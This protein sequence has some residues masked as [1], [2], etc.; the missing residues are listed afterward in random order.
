MIEFLRDFQNMSMY[1]AYNT[2]VDAIIY[3]NEK[4]IQTLIKEFGAENVK[5]RMQE[6]PRE[7][8]EPLDFVARLIHALKTGKPQSVPLMSYEVD[9]WFNSRFEHGVERIGGQV[10][11]IANLLANL[12]FKKV[13][14]YSPLL[15]K[16]QAEMFVRRDNLLYPVVENGKLI[17]KKP[18]EAYKE[19]DPVK[20]NRIF[21]FRAGMRFNLGNEV[22][23]VPY[24]GRFI[25]ACRSEEFARVETSSNFKPYLPEI[26]EMVDGAILSGYQGIRNHYTD[27]KNANYYLRKAKEDI[28]LLKKKKDVKIHVEFASI[29]DRDLRKKVIFNIFPLADSVGMDEA[30]IAHILSVLGYRDLSDRIFTYNRIEDTILGAK[31]L[32]DELNLEVLQIHTI[33]YLMYITHRDNPL[34]EGDLLK[35]LEVGTTLA[36]TRAL[37]GDIKRP[38]DVKV[39]LNIPFNEKGEYVKLR[40]EEALS[41]MRTR[42]YKIVITPTRIVKN[43]VSTVGLGDTISAGAFASYLSLLMRKGAY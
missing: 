42:E 31:I 36:A 6:Y 15:G 30:E 1:L 10:G 26:G 13:I 41:K 35:S 3:L 2:N 27:G 25:V 33:Y 11:I 32:L 29:Q 18:L 21:E 19:D 5:K 23:E 4:H 17:L 16:K 20:I 9:K 28:K 34:S 37:L 38:E 7:I 40:L 22:I 8:N 14:A 39:G 24:S 12:D 43:P